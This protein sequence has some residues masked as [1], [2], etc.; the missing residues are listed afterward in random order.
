MT[1]E[2]EIAGALTGRPVQTWR[3]AVAV[4]VAAQAWARQGAPDGA[5]VI[6]GYQASPRGRS[7]R[8]WAVDQHRDLVLSVIVRPDLAPEDEGRLYTVAVLAVSDLCG[9]DIV[10]PD[11]V[12]SADGRSVGAVS[13]HAELGPSAV[14]WAVLTVN[15]SDIDDRP[16]SAA[17]LLAALD[18]RRAA[19]PDLLVADH[20]SRCCTLGRRVAARMIP[21][22]PAGP[23][24][25]GQAVDVLAD[26]ALVILSDRGAR[27]AVRPQNLGML[28]DLDGVDD[29]DQGAG[30]WPPAD[31]SPG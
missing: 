31:P 19:G 2:E 24:V 23:V 27:V 7:G 3:A 13:V 17:A 6:V 9:G 5:V 11:R 1:P 30:D 12:I 22:G 18:E 25:T 16:G 4:D 15:L 20:R 26:G 28:D 29:P 10:W 14:D 21:L 8:P